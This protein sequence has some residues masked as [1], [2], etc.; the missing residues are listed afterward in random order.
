MSELQRT[1]RQQLLQEAEGYLELIMVFADQWP[2]HPV[3]RDRLARRAL[4]TLDRIIY[5]IKNDPRVTAVYLDGHTDNIGRRYDNRQISKRRVEAVERYFLVK[6]IAPE[7]I[8]TRFHGSRY[9]V[10]NNATAKG[11][12]ENRRVTVRLEID[13]DMPLPDELVFELP[14]DAAVLP[15]I[16]RSVSG[17]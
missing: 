13:K 12:A 15:S 3:S 8:T 7:I 9:P 2:P 16:N 11:R 14:E 17:R 10:A 4:D 5:Y 1:R 6:G